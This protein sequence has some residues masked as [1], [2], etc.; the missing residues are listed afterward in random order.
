LPIRLR[1][2]VLE[3]IAR[4]IESVEEFG[5]HG[6]WSVECEKIHPINALIRAG[7]S[8]RFISRRRTSASKRLDPKGPSRKRKLASE[9]HRASDLLAE[10]RRLARSVDRIDQQLDKRATKGREGLKNVM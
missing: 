4:R 1:E 7:I 8:T 10:K 3:K 2:R 5:A 9:R 6:A